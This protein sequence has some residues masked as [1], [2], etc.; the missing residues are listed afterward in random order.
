MAREDI[1]VGLEIGTS[2]VCAVVAECRKDG[3]IHLLGVGE[4]PSRGVRKGEIVDFENAC[5]C[6]R[7]ALSDAQ[8][9]SDVEISDVWLAVTGSHIQSFNNRG[10]VV[11]PDEG[12]EITDE[13]IQEV[14]YKAK[15]IS[16]PKENTILHS[17]IQ[18]YY[19]DG[20]EGVLNPVG[21]LGSRLEADFHIIHGVTNR[22]QNSI[23]C[24]KECDIEVLDVVS[25]SLASA[26]VVLGQ[27]QKEAG[28]LVVDIGGGVTDY[29]VYL[30][31]AVRHSGV[32]AV[33]GDHI[34]N[35]ISIG[36][37]IPITRAE[38][39]KVE[40]GSAVLGKSLPGDKIVLKNDTGFSGKEVEREMLNM[41][42]HAR[43]EEL[44]TLLRKRLG[45][46]VPQHLLGAGVML[47]G[48]CSMI[49]GIRE[50]AES[51]FEMPVQLT[52][53]QAVTGPTS[54]FENPQFS[55]CI[56]LAKYAQ[57]VRS[58]MPEESL[59]GRVIRKISR[60]FHLPF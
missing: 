37:R 51:V 3:D 24:V 48:G 18:H 59:G 14:E 29:I 6:V 34:T 47:T 30:G 57:A 31:G 21:M 42:I 41:I 58:E 44:F 25:S 39:L 50:V 16:L 54:A 38:K 7:E 45:D 10:S 2:K 60:I 8:E 19:V 17:I 35:D 12:G 28:A 46:D 20:Q 33:G 1:Q 52:R 15:E 49:R 56:G 4:A 11:I 13:E 40:E 27:H 32:L 5:N 36:L 23:R 53:A 43:L 9:K 55:T 22:I 26:Q